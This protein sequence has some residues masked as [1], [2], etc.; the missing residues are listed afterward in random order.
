[1]FAR[2]VTP[3]VRGPGHARDSDGYASNEDI[4]TATPATTQTSVSSHLGSDADCSELDTSASDVLRAGGIPDTPSWLTARLQDMLTAHM[5]RVDAELF[6]VHAD[7]EEKVSL[8]QMKQSQVQE[9]VIVLAE[10]QAMDRTKM[11]EMRNDLRAIMAE[12][13]KK[14][15]SAKTLEHVPVRGKESHA[16]REAPDLSN[17]TAEPEGE[18]NSLMTG[19]EGR[20]A[21]VMTALQ[22]LDDHMSGYEGQMTTASSFACSSGASRNS[23]RRV[24][25]SPREQA[26]DVSR[27]RN[28]P[29]H[30]HKTSSSSGGSSSTPPSA[31]GSECNHTPVTGEAKTEADSSTPCSTDQCQHAG[32]EAVDAQEYLDAGDQSNLTERSVQA[33]PANI[34]HQ[35][36][37]TDSEA[38]GDQTLRW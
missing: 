18:M 10:T 14:Q 34:N 11:D 16:R 13:T 27:A 3:A 1:V 28:S 33:E 25:K 12:L 29:S 23:C 5:F 9:Q 19:Y 38:I 22:D 8:V 26:P 2:G 36:A 24:F 37:T 4:P 31:T 15:V 20:M 7:L 6:K 35:T 21:A 30:V 32:K 17:L